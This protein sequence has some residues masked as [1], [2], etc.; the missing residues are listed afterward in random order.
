MTEGEGEEEEVFDYYQRDTIAITVVD[1]FEVSRRMHSQENG[2]CQTDSK[3]KKAPVRHMN[4]Q[5]SNAIPSYA[6]W[7]NV[8]VQMMK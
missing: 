3:A 7:T 4:H 5:E 1:V 2:S 6:A 8:M